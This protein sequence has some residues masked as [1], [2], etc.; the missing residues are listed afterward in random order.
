LKGRLS[1]RTRTFG[2]FRLTRHNRLLAIVSVAALVITVM[3]IA[4]DSVS[5]LCSV[6]LI[7]IAI[8]IV[9]IATVVV[10]VPSVGVRI[11]DSDI[12]VALTDDHTKLVYRLCLM[13]LLITRRLIL[14]GS[15]F[16]ATPLSSFRTAAVVA[17]DNGPKERSNTIVVVTYWFR[18]FGLLFRWFLLLG[19]TL[20]LA[21][22]GCGW[23]FG[24][25]LATITTS[26]FAAA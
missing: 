13:L 4:S 10:R 23:H 5:T 17:H 11:R 2:P 6:T 20:T 26:C 12:V 18:W 21:S 25:R 15:F 14:D 19:F 16:G 7:A 9:L 22:C 8:A 3:L 1:T 24:R